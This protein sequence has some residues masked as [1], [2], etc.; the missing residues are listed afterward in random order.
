MLS[1]IQTDKAKYQSPNSEITYNPPVDFRPRTN[2][3]I[4]LTALMYRCIKESPKQL[5]V[6]HHFR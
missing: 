5:L 3:A 4:P 1:H 6:I 2:K